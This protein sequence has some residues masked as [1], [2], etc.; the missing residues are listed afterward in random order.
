MIMAKRATIGFY[1]DWKTK[2]RGLPLITARGT[3]INKAINKKYLDERDVSG[4]N[5][6]DLMIRIGK[7][8]KKL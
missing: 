7:A 4:T 8:I 2:I 1:T 6:G 5:V 3:M